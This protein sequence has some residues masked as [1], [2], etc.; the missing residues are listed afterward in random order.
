M[1]N[2][3]DTKQ[4]GI[5]FLAE[6]ESNILKPDYNSEQDDKYQKLLFEQNTLEKKLYQELYQIDYKLK[7]ELSNYKSH[8]QALEFITKQKIQEKNILSIY[9]SIEN[10][11]SALGYDL[12]FYKPEDYSLRNNPF[13]KT[14]YVS[15]CTTG[16]LGSLYLMF[17]GHFGTALLTWFAGAIIDTVKNRTSEKISKQIEQGERAIKKNAYLSGRKYRAYK[18]IFEDARIMWLIGNATFGDNI[19]QEIDSIKNNLTSNGKEREKE[20]TACDLLNLSSVTLTD[21]M[22]KNTDDLLKLLGIDEEIK[23][24]EQMYERKK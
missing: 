11:T 18:N 15:Y 4:F 17:S 6:F 7:H 23:K 2:L 10:I 21:F 1:D 19:F 14:M 3:D 13:L 22:E 5:D 8:L 20:E 24:Y 9:H 16:I 12:K